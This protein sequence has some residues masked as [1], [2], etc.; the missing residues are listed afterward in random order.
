[1]NLLLVEDEV[2]IRTRIA[3][4][5]PWDQHGI[6][7]VGMAQNG[8]E[9]LHIVKIKKVDIMLVDIQMPEMDGL[10][11]AA[12]INK[13]HPQVCMIILS[14]YEQ[15]EY[16]QKAVQ[17]G[18]MKYLLKPARNE[19]ILEAVLQAKQKIQSE[20]QE[21]FNS[22]S[23]REKWS[24]HLSALQSVFWNNWV[25]GQYAE[26][27][28]LHKGGELQLQLPEDRLYQVGILAIDPLSDEDS[29][30]SRSDESLLQFSIQSITK[31]VLENDACY[32]FQDS[33]GNTTVIFSQTELE[34]EEV[35][36]HRVNYSLTRLLSIVKECLKVTASAGIGQTARRLTDVARSYSQ[37][38]AALQ[39]RVIYG[40]YVAIHSRDEKESADV[41]ELPAAAI[42]KLTVALDMCSK[43]LVLEAVEELLEEMIQPEQSIE[44][45]Q[46]QVLLLSS[47]LVQWMHGKGL[48]SKEVLGAD[49]HYYL[50]N[51]ELKSRRQIKEWLVRSLY[52]VLAY[53]DNQRTKGV[54]KLTSAVV[55]IIEANLHENLSLHTIAE[56]LFVNSSYLSRLFKMQTGQ[57]FS[58]Y[59]ITKKMEKAKELL[60]QGDK[61]QDV[62]SQ[63]GYIN[64][65]YF[66]RTFA[67]IWGVLPS[68][69]RG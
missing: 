19:E 46:L 45:I 35:F 61:V 32:V 37:A 69:L 39:E 10:T 64:V 25:T 20:Q 3:E 7:I 27:E 51:Q 6:T 13:C 5:I 65:S 41:R 21:R 33:T 11:L 2:G 4:F 17:L 52:A 58:Q 60:L 55:A 31:E 23:L 47:M 36:C 16:A 54:N 26:W 59:V 40:H 68:E 12:E 49:L 15:F 43:E 24:Y 34:N 1:M 29:R 56:K 66:S 67:K 18:V 8:I 62:A 9:A 57:P 38:N 48:L 30:F 28:I 63:V 50:N 42:K 22:I 53:L 44:E 14:G